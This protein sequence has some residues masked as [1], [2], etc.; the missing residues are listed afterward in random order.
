MNHYHIL[1]LPTHPAFFFI[2]LRQQR[3]YSYDAR[4]T[5]R[6]LDSANG[7]VV[8]V[9]VT[10]LGRGLLGEQVLVD[11][12]HDTAAGDGGAAEKLRQLLIVADSELN[13]ARHNAG[14]LVVPR[15][16]PGELQDLN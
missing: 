6:A 14:L 10:R 2:K 15:G 9:V 12:G 1:L 16:V 4:T 3:A 8:V 7:S 11:V 13:V 5:R